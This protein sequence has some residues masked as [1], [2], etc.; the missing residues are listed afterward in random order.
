MT[1]IWMFA[2]VLGLL[3]LTKVAEDRLGEDEK[4]DQLV[5]VEEPRRGRFTV[6]GRRANTWKSLH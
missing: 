2:V 4:F 6:A 1:L 5:K 3:W